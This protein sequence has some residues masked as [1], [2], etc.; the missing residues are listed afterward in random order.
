[1]EFIDLA[2]QQS[3]IKEGIQTRIE[4][5]LKHGKYIM[6]PE[7]YDLE[8]KLTNYV[9]AKHCI[10]CSSGTDALL[11][12]LMAKGIGH[13]DAILTTPFSYIATAEVIS[14]VHATPIFVDSEKETWNMSPELLEDAIMHRIAHGKKPKAI[15]VVHLYGMPAKMNEIIGS[16]DII[17]GK[18]RHG[19]TGNIQVQFEGIYTKFKDASKT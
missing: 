5:V 16:A 3:L 2:K 18:Q 12:A 8:E 14:L 1:M 11:I 19:P 13:G 9:G 7:V 15:I 6:G 17:I 4:K 10:T